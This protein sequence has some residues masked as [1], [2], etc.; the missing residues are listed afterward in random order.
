MFV[1]K[2]QQ[3]LALEFGGCSMTKQFSMTVQSGRRPRGR[4]IWL[5]VI[6]LW[7]AAPAQ[8]NETDQYLLPLD[9][10]W[11]D[12]GEFMSGVHHMV[13]Q[14]AI[15]YVNARIERSLKIR[16]PVQRQR[17]L[18]RWQA[19]EA[20][21]DSV[22]RLWGIGFW[23]MM[24]LDH[25]LHSRK[26][27][28]AFP[29]QLV[30]Y[31]TW[32]WLY[33]YVHLPIDP[34]NIPLLLPSS[35]IK[36]FDVYIG[37]DKFG[38]LHDLGHIYYKDYIWG[39]RNGYDPDHVMQ[40]VVQRFSRGLISESML[41][42][43]WA[44]GVCS[45]AD[46]A[47]N[48]IGMK[49]YM[50]LTEATRIQGEMHPPMLVRDGPFWRFNDHIEPQTLLRPFI[51]DHLNEALNPNLYEWGARMLVRRRLNQIAD[52]VLA[53]YADE[54]GRPRP[55]QWFDDKAE[56]LRTYYGDDYGHRGRRDQLITIGDLHRPQAPPKVAEVAEVAAEP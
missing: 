48:Y 6:S 26:M 41:I 16:G 43:F 5:V 4:M 18:E 47:A 25:F 34:R 2:F 7:F 55:A 46:T 20:V 38:H 27:R 23:D 39:I 10:Q 51:T 11:A 40:V 56:E 52:H 12:L 14:D 1:L 37:V 44:T 53:V 22:R 17:A 30:A 54:H 35:T 29:D 33:T 45:N 9:A 49:F 31:K 28:R 50:N 32:N 42:G 15:N 19:P 3:R 24:H 36:V 8:G 21:A 13:V